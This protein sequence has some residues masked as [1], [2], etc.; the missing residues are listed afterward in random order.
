MIDALLS[1]KGAQ[2]FAG[3]RVEQKQGSNGPVQFITGKE[4]LSGLPQELKDKFTIIEE[5]EF[6]VDI[7]S[8][9]IRQKEEAERLAGAPKDGQ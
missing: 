1:M 9:E 6:R 8:T 4:E 2:F 7:S 3:G 5:Q